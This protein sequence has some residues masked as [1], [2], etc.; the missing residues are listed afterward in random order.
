[1]NT[2]L[3]VNKPKGITSFDVCYK[4]RKVFN[5]KRIGH[6]GTLDPNA[7]GVMI[8]LIDEA[9][10]AAQFLVS[11]TKEYYARVKFGIETD[12]LDI[13]GNIIKKSDYQMPSQKEIENVLISFL[14]KS[15]QIV[16]LTSA[17]KI[18]G[19]KLYQYKN[20]NQDVDLPVIDIEVFSIKLINL[21]EDGFD[22]LVSVSSGTYIRS[23]VRDICLKLNIVGT[24][25]E[26]KRTKI[27]QISIDDC[28]ELT[29]ILD[30][31]YKHHSLL[32]V[33]KTRYK[34]FD[35][36]NVDDVKNGKR[37]NIDSNDKFV[38][39]TN[40]DELIAMYTKDGSQYKSARGLW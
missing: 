17:K 7:T 12:S 18:N 34:T 15:K 11:D 23:L 24:T 9:T 4:L 38:L 40:N 39:I 16:P 37:L 6:T 30:G 19:K 33:L 14:G 31:N 10:K 27:D 2:V 35:I 20:D 32:D 22:F 8:V 36:N 28:D 3:Y 21:N 5:T 25:L 1:M 26:L 29:D 13:C